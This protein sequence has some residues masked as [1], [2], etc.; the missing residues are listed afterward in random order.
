[1]T[2]LKDS[3]SVAE[4]SAMEDT[5]RRRSHRRP[6]RGFGLIAAAV[7][8]IVVA[9]CAAADTGTGSASTSTAPLRGMQPIGSLPV[10]PAPATGVA[11]TTSSPTTG[12]TPTTTAPPVRGTHILYSAIPPGQTTTEIYRMRA[13]GTDAVRLTSDQTQEHL[14]PRPSPD[15]SKVLFYTAAPG[16]TVTDIDTNNLWVMDEDGSHQRMLL[17]DGAYGWTRQG[18]VEWSP[19]GTRLIM[20][21]GGSTTTDLY[22]TDAEGRNPTKVTDRGPHMAIDPSWTPDGRSALFIGCPKESPTCWWWE[23]EVYRIDLDSGVEQRL[24]ADGFPDFD[25]YMSPDGSQVV[26][27]RCTG[28][29]PF[30]PWG[31]FR[32]PTTTVPLQPSAV[33]DDGNIN[34]SVDFSA[35]GS[36]LLFSRHVIGETT[37]Q[38]A[39]TVGIDGSRLGFVGGAPAA[40][41]QG[42]PVYWP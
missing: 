21:A 31:I 1:M 18:H 26:W 24:T 36:T 39:A 2:T 30:G 13:N 40:I 33:V 28:L 4:H 34:S 32:A 29:F 8:A 3:V 38:S 42:T 19:D 22:V 7:A 20:A 25:P 12:V 6:R 10:A 23:Y 37:W 11:P 14:W 27:L 41:G 15:G 9:G 5:A 17:A 16:S 35:D